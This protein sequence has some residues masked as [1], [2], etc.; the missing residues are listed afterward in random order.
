MRLPARGSLLETTLTSVVL[1]AAV[2]C[3]INELIDDG[4]A[5][6]ILSS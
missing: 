2:I 1:S 6:Q 5:F 3:W 4:I